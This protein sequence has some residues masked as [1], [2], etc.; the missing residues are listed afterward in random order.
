M[1]VGALYRG[2]Q[3]VI[4]RVY[5]ADTPWTRLRGLLGRPPLA[6]DGG[7]G[8]LLRPCNA[9]HTFGIR[10]A[11][12]LVFLDARG[13]VIKACEQV[14]PGTARFCWRARET[15]ELA[16]GSLERMHPQAGEVLDW[17]AA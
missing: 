17:R 16:A 10:Y 11:L 15:L 14:R 1:R 12:D 6:A 3:C 13:A 2:A 8:I 4:A 5:L 7:E 9:V